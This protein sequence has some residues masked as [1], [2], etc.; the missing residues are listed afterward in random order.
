MFN[1]Y[2]IEAIARDRVERRHAQAAVNRLVR[3]T[4]TTKSRSGVRWRRPARST[5]AD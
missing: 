1:R 3:G 2:S 5:H 4:A